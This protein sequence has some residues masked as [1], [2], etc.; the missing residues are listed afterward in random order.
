MFWGLQST[1]LPGSDVI[2]ALQSLLTGRGPVMGGT[3]ALVQALVRLIEP[4]PVIKLFGFDVDKDA[5]LAVSFGD[6]FVRCRR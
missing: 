3:G 1:R 4:D 2:T 6:L 5:T